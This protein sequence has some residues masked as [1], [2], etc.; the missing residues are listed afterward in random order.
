MGFWRNLFTRPVGTRTVVL[1]HLKT[2][3][4]ALEEVLSR[5]RLVTSSG[6]Y[7]DADEV[8]AHTKL[9]EAHR[10][11]LEHVNLLE[12]TIKEYGD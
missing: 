8:A 10:I 12:A 2:A 7:A 6:G 1:R 9:K 11:V 5:F 4:D 3:E